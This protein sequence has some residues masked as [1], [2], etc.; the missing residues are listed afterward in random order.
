M[1]KKRVVSRKG[2][3][4]KKAAPA[5]KAVG[6]TK[7]KKAAP[8]KAAKKKKAAPKWIDLVEKHGVLL[9]AAR[10]PVLNVADLVVGEPIVGGWWAHP[11]GK[12][13]F[14]ALSQI[15]DSDDIRSFRLIDGKVTFAHRRVWPALVRLGRDGI[16]DADRL[17]S[18]QQVHTPTGEHRTTVVPFPDWVDERT[19]IAADA[20]SD[21]AAREMLPTSELW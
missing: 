14:E 17:G 4:K 1:K 20:L 21:A 11:K 19:A 12:Q 6:K 10:G 9:A 2:T 18:V 5:K 13:I 7:P 3:A 16:F 15:D 8:K